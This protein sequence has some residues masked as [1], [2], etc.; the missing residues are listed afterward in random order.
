MLDEDEIE[1][2]G[3]LRRGEPQFLEGEPKEKAEKAIAR[4]PRR[5]KKEEEPVKV[6][7]VEIAPQE[8]E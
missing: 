5:V 4:R 7:E 3:R 1:Q 8:E 2:L 6:S